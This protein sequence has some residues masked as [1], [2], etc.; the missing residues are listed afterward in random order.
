MR[1]LFLPTEVYSWGDCWCWNDFIPEFSPALSIRSCD[2]SEF[3][4]NTYL[5]TVVTPWGTG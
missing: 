2:S 4:V 5:W 1:P 3:M